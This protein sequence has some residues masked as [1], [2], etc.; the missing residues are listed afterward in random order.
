MITMVWVVTFRIDNK[1]P[2]QE[3]IRYTPEAAK[4]FAEGI[5]A[6]GGVAVV[7]EDVQ[8]VTTDDVNENTNTKRSLKW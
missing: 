4:H 1:S 8:D 5:I 7:T 6:T 2:Q 3:L